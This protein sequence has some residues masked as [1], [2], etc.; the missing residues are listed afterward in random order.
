M[1]CVPRY[2]CVPSY[3]FP[4]SLQAGAASTIALANDRPVCDDCRGRNGTG[5]MKITAGDSYR[6]PR[7]AWQHVSQR[8]VVKD[9]TAAPSWALRQLAGGGV[10]QVGQPRCRSV[11]ANA[12][13]WPA[14]S[15]SRWTRS[16]S[17]GTAEWRARARGNS[18]CGC[19]CEVAFLCRWASAQLGR[20]HA[21][22]API[23][24]DHVFV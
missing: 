15:F 9:H 18:C 20:Q 21:C 7:V 8:R 16:A 1:R 17:C 4:A 10:G 12:A 13:R 23:H 5:S 24:C 2:R 11:P 22:N 14:S 3:H 19:D 6:Q